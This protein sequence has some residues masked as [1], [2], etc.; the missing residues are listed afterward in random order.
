MDNKIYI[1]RQGDSLYRIATWFYFRWDMYY[2]VWLANRQKI[3]E[4]PHNLAVGLELTIHRVFTEEKTHV[5]NASEKL[6]DIAKQYYG[7]REFWH[8]LAK[9]NKITRELSNGQKLVVPPL[10]NQLEIDAAK[11]VRER[12]RF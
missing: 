6:T 3:G 9:E 4:N 12:L 1:T 2:L 8:M 10:V 5:A 7:Y 11:E